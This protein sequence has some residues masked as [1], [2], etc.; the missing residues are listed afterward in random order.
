[1]SAGLARRPVELANLSLS[2]VKTTALR[3]SRSFQTAS[4]PLKCRR[5]TDCGSTSPYLWGPL[6]QDASEG[7]MSTEVI[8][9]RSCRQGER[10]PWTS[11]CKASMRL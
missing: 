9:S 6:H 8:K 4:P 3:P 5:S 2:N 7:T 1:M 11:D 10:M